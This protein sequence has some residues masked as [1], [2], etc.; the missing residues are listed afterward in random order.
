MATDAVIAVDDLRV[1][2]ATRQGMLEVIHGVS[3]ALHRGKT[4]AIVGESGSGKS[5]TARAILNMVPSPGSITGGRIHFRPDGSEPTD[6]TSLHPR[7]KAIRRIRGGRIGM[8][9]QEP[10]S[11]LS[12]VHT[13]GSQVVEAVRLHRD[14]GTKEARRLALEMLEQVEIPKPERALDQYAFEFSGGMRQRAMI[15]MA[16][17][18]HP[19]VLIA[20]EPTTAL[21]VTTQAEILDLMGR[22]QRELGMAIMFITHDMGVVAET[23]DDVVVMEQGV[24]VERGETTALFARPAHPYTQKLLGAVKRLEEPAAAKVRP[25]PEAPEVLRV[26]DLKLHF[27]KREGF[28]QRVTDTTRAVDGISFTLRK[29]EALGLVGESGSGKTTVGRCI[30][31]VYE[32][33]AGAIRYEGADLSSLAREELRTFRRRIRMIFQDPFASLNPRMTVKQIVGEPLT[34][35]GLAGG[36]ELEDR[37]AG[38]LAAVG[39]DTAMMERY[40]HAFSGGPAPADRRCPRHRARAAAG[41]RRRTDQRPRRVHPDAG[42]RSSPPASG[43]TRAFLS[44]HLARHGGDPLLLRSGCGHVSRTD[45]RNRRDRGCHHE[46]A[47]SLHEGASLFGSDTGSVPSRYA[48]PAPLYR[49]IAMKIESVEAR[50]FSH[51]SREARDTDGH[52]HP[53]PEHRTVSAL[54]SVVCDDGTTGCSIASPGDI[55]EPLLETFVRPVLL[56]RDPLRPEALWQAL[57][58]WQRGSAMKLTDRTL[59]AVDLAIWDLV[60]KAAAQPVWKLLGGYR[61][62]LP[63]YGSTMCGDDLEGGLATP[64]DYARFAE[65]MVR[66]RGY[67]AVKLHT[68]MPPIPGAPDVR[69]DYA[70]CAAVREAVGPDVPLMLDP[71]HWYS[72]TDSLWL[73]RKLEELEFFWI[74]E[75]MEEASLSSYR[76]LN[77]R[78]PSLNILGPEKMSGKHWTRAEWAASGACDMLRTGVWDVGGI[79][80]A[81]KTARLAESFHMSCELHGTG[82]G[83]LAVAA[84]IPNTNFYERGLLHPFLDYD[85]PGD[86]QNRIDDEMDGD[87]RV[88]C[89][90]TPGLGQDLDLDYIEANLV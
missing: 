52:A 38:L 62:R 12:P 79:T 51:R 48:P 67:Q 24:V 8:I 49:G 50:V 25:E 13:I 82:A 6:L 58:K 61:D 45:R 81:M 36:R 53:G 56:G 84:A 43:R 9:F 78:V 10:M 37:V 32:P 29:G 31:R 66:E 15:A 70:A 17:S 2:F 35:H 85:R 63:A 77:A 30:A 68:W 11:S 60:G 87:G 42:A 21:D 14:I 74:E 41:H 23:S 18:C 40:P 22:L 59:A 19:D 65:W 27:D 64:G 28:L 88:H 75:M 80:P 69:K 39:L 86:Y 90:E 71:N 47:A 57:Y 5:V 16:L 83:N 44:L 1:G 46:S 54:L 33:T 26:D 72:R 76:W 7:G 3:F 89:R 20:D 73:C 34:V 55:E 4:T